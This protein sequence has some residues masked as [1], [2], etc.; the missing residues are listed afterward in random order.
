VTSIDNRKIAR[1]AK[2]AG[3]P[4]VKA[5]GVEMHVRVGDTVEAGQ[6]VCTLHA[7]TPAELNYALDYAASTEDIVGI[8]P[9]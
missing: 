2:L 3:A 6:P 1:L 4:E 5:A 7:E 9:R 8:E